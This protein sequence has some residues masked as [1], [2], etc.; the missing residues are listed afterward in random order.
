M[1]SPGEVSTSG[2]RRRRKLDFVR[3]AV[4][5]TAII[6]LAAA[7]ALWTV[8]INFG[9]FISLPR[10]KVVLAWLATVF[11]LAWFVSSVERRLVEQ[12]DRIERSRYR[13]GYIDGYIDASGR[14]LQA[15]GSTLHRL[16]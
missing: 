7:G 16:R 13:D 3:A 10:L 6:A 2:H 1:A 5:L 8:E 11:V 15:K 12:L 4:G 9:Y 14:R